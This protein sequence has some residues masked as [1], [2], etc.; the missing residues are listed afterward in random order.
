MSALRYQV[1][2][3]LQIGVQGDDSLDDCACF[4]EIGDFYPD[5]LDEL[6]SLPAE[7]QYSVYDDSFA[8]EPADIAL[9]G[10]VYYNLLT[11]LDSTCYSET[12]CNW[13]PE[14][15]SLSGENSTDGELC[16]SGSTEFC[17]TR[18]DTTSPFYFEVVLV[19]AEDCEN[20]ESVCVLST[21]AILLGPA[22]KEKCDELGVCSGYCPS[23][24]LTCVPENP[25]LPSVCYREDISE[26]DCLSGLGF[27]S[28]EG[29][30]V[31][32]TRN[33]PDECRDTDQE[34]ELYVDGAIGEI[35][36]T[37]CSERDIDDC[38]V[39]DF[40]VLT[41]LAAPIRICL[42]EEDCEE[43]GHGKCEDIEFFPFQGICVIPFIEGVDRL[44]CFVNL[45]VTNIGFF[46]L[47]FF[48]L[49]F[50]VFVSSFS[51][52]KL[53]LIIIFFFRR[54]GNPYITQED[55][56]LNSDLGWVYRFPSVNI[57]DC[58]AYGYGCL[59][60]KFSQTG[61][62]ES[63]YTDPSEYPGTSIEDVENSCQ[64]ERG[65]IMPL[66]EWEEGVWASGKTVP[67]TR[68]PKRELILLN[69]EA[70]ILD[71]VSL[72]SIVENSVE[73]ENF[74]LLQNLVFDFLFMSFFFFFYFSLM[75]FFLNLPFLPS[76]LLFLAQALCATS[77]SLIESLNVTSCSCLPELFEGSWTGESCSY[78]F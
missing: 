50:L 49:F 15:R 64:R 60:N 58:E 47:L 5:C 53:F 62:L 77:Y 34:K 72:G 4:H 48:F 3:V 36:F 45:T 68:V 76:S 14:I 78:R 33:S 28:F 46:S 37:S 9:G 35:N 22:E 26:E 42:D 32:M 69:K 39:D 43:E 55:C 66:F 29:F 44:F 74:S 18:I 23:E 51:L 17:G 2:F 19:T 65:E 67:T 56:E 13:N 16:L 6:C 24:E 41:C 52:Q 7:C 27:L 12:Q 31:Y 1:H 70:D 30:C 63:Y 38:V 25:L 71:F 75:I 8:Y 61:I 20:Q 10:C 21:G 59:T 57:E 11:S 54:C 40:S 73:I